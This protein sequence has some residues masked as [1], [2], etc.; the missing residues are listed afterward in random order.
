MEGPSREGSTDPDDRDRVEGMSRDGIAG[1]VPQLIG[2]AVVGS[3][4][5]RASASGWL[6]PIDRGDDPRD[7][8]VEN[9]NA[10]SDAG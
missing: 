4:D 6:A 8:A 3:D 1:G 7:A 9:P 10:K 2:V 5:E